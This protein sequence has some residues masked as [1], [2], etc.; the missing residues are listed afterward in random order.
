MGRRKRRTREHVL[1]DLGINHVER[2]IFGCGFSC[3]R[4]A[5]DYGI[6]LLMFTYGENGE[7][8]NGHVE[9]Q[10]K[11]TDHPKYRK[12]EQTVGCRVT[13]A[14]FHYWDGQPWPVILV[15]YDAKADRG[16]WLYMQR[17]LETAKGRR[18]IVGY[19]DI[20]P[21]T[22]T[23]RIPV[24]NLLDCEAITRFR[25]FRDHVLEQVKG[26]IRHDN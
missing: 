23:I 8:E 17:E 19:G 10:V 7:I 3:E 21:K 13:Y 15:L 12:E 14:D 5:H 24:T 26:I 16:Y 11:A 18:Q 2:F 22:A 20:S 9:I 1:A 6:D 4:V 25:D